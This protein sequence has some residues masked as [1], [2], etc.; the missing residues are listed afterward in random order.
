LGVAEQKNINHYQ[1]AGN[2]NQTPDLNQ[3][4]ETAVLMT[5]M[6]LMCYPCNNFIS[7]R[8]DNQKVAMTRCLARRLRK[9][10]EERNSLKCPI[11]LKEREMPTPGESPL[12]EHPNSC[13]GCEKCWLCGKHKDKAD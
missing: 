13:A 8:L 2:I 3:F 10:H 12:L 5:Q 9:Q 7:D 1:K 11:Q 4:F 6:R